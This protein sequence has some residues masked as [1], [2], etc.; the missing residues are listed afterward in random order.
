[1]R[2][3]TERSDVVPAA[4]GAPLVPLTRSLAALAA[5]LAL[6]PPEAL[7]VTYRYASS[8][9]RIYAEN[10]GTTTLTAIKA[11]LP[12]APLS[13]T[14]AGVWLLRA[15]LMI[16]DGVT[17]NLHG[18]AV[19]GDVNELRLQSDGGGFVILAA[20]HG[21]LDIR[22]TRIRSWNPSAAA[23]DTTT[24]DGRAYIR[25]RSYLDSDGVTP[26]ESRMDIADSEI[27]HLGYNAAEAYGLVWKVIGSSPGLYDKVNV[28]GDIR[29]SNIHH[30]YFGVYTYGH[31]GG[32]W[33]GNEV[34]HNIKYG[35]DPHDDSDN[36]LIE[37][38]D[39]HDNGNH[40]IIASKRCH[41]VVI[42][43]N[44]SYGNI[45]NGIML[46]RSSNDGVIEG[47]Q[48][49]LNTD[50]GIALFANRR[51]TVR[52][53]ILLDNGVAGIR[54]SMG[55]AD[56]LVE[57]NQIG[58]SGKY[59]LYFY[60]G[61]DTPEPGDDGRPKRNTFRNNDIHDIAGDG[62]KMTDGDA[63]TFVG[64]TFRAIGGSLRFVT[65]TAVKLSNNDIPATTLVDIRGSSTVAGAVDFD[66]QP[67]LRLRL[68]DDSIAKFRDRDNAIFDP[69]E[70]VYTTSS[71]TSSLL[72][73]TAANTGG[74]TTVRTRALRAVPASGKVRVNPT[75]WNLGGD[76][77][78]QW[79]I[80]AD[81]SSTSVAYTVGDLAPGVAYDVLRGSAR[82]ATLTASSAGAIAF[83][84]APGS[85]STVTYTVQPR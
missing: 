14:G 1:M 55:E 12:N 67:L 68:D 23:V 61:S 19:G 82:I 13:E 83:A 49:Y 17:L 9:N 10:G 3:R 56:S 15:S 37:D 7:A 5:L 79:R 4:P 76:L 34:H 71:T 20:E 41:N 65:S 48:S 24:S 25:V 36:L 27:S 26:R 28:R 8:S 18:A 74:S 21:T 66:T 62:I 16:E 43:N 72:T 39:V 44:R 33:I 57:G 11:A 40:G 85:T 51:S 53:N 54:L 30:N 77:A 6:L 81:A 84:S 75:L 31:D 2:F 32:R 64:N 58:H 59:G 45:G 46:H 63:N 22:S 70:S 35:L 69:D 80:R 60:R 50:S 73:L 78:K 42:R 52:N 29:N 38:N 47:N